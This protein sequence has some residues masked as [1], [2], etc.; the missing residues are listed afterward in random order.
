MNKKIVKPDYN[1]CILSISSSIMKKYK[2]KSN[3]NTLPELDEILEN[4]YRNIIFLILDCLGTNIMK[5]NL[6]EDSILRSNL[7]TE[8]TSV[9]PPTTAA[10]TP[11]F[12]SGLSP[13]E[14]GWIGWMPYFKE[15]NK[16]IE[17]FSGKD[18]YT[19]EQIIELPEKSCL[20]YKTIYEK[21]C[22]TNTSIYDI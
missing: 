9:F 15:Y 4:N 18:F 13:F 20:K 19:G 14:N 12:H 3:Y 8:V 1:R 10:A 22:N 2:V 6:K 17:L 11:A 21:I 7:I 5:N 16:M